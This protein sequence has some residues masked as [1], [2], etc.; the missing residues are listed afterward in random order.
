MPETRLSKNKRK[1]NKVVVNNNNDNPSSKDKKLRNN[2]S[3]INHEDVLYIP[4]LD[5]KNDIVGFVTS[6]SKSIRSMFDMLTSLYHHGSISFF[7]KKIIL[8]CSTKCIV[9]NAEID[10][11][12]CDIEDHIFNYKKIKEIEFKLLSAATNK[13]SMNVTKK[14][15]SEDYEKQDMMMIHVALP[16][17]NQCMS[18]ITHADIFCLRMTEE[19]Y[20]KNELII[21]IHHKKNRYVHKFNVPIEHNRNES[22]KNQFLRHIELGENKKFD[23]GLHMSTQEFLQTLRT[24]K[25]SGN[26]IQ[27]LA[28]ECDDKKNWCHFCTPG[29]GVGVDVISSHRFRI[30]EEL[31]T[32]FLNNH[33]ATKNLVKVTDYHNKEIIKSL[34]Q[35]PT[36][37]IFCNT[38]S[39]YSTP[40]LMAMAKTSSMSRV[41]SIFC[42]NKR[43][44]IG[45]KHRIGVIGTLTC[46]MSP[47]ED[48]GCFKFVDNDKGTGKYYIVKI[49]NKSTLLAKT[50]HEEINDNT[51]KNEDNISLDT[52]IQCAN[53]FI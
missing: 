48:L 34:S 37:K 4:Q 15:S 11:D 26:S 10:A 19:S 42:N 8:G 43:D 32:A 50:N 9:V 36:C 52:A 25:K 53:E 6:A 22:I 17:L 33:L 31:S 12:S 29:M 20:M 35:T 14:L 23:I 3:N 2:T 49:K 45:L 13:F 51:N 44:V 27:I 41:I 1:N 28:G 47:L 18:S 7:Q 38:N 40:L 21:E 16:I 39:C 30:E 24:A 5:R 46:M